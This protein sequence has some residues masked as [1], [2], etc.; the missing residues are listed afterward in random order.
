MQKDKAIVYE[1]FIR[2]SFPGTW[3]NNTTHLT[4]QLHISVMRHK[5]ITYKDLRLRFYHCF[6]IVLSSD[7]YW[8]NLINLN[9]FLRANEDV[10]ARS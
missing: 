10:K 2:L 1:T 8:H 5:E 7:L 3:H 9:P 4:L 6:S